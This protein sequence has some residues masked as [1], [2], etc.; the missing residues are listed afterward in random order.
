MPL[1]K[2]AERRH[3]HTRTVDCAGYRRSDG[4]WDIE[5]HLTDV[6]SYG[7]ANAERGTIEPGDP[8]HEMW[9]RVTV[10]DRLTIVAIE[11]QTDKSPFG[12][13]GAIT[14]A[15]QQLVGLSMVS[16]FTR[17]VK[18]RVGGVHGCTHLAE[19]LGPVATTAFQTVFPI[20]SRERSEKAGVRRG[21]T[22]PPLLN[23]CHAFASDGEL[24]RQLWPNHYTGPE[25]ALDV[26]S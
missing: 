16:G 26:A 11:A 1:S 19:L 20:L 14:P 5:G 21:D 8:I 6:K 4:L 12:I 24:V 10:D 17:K 15:F 3:I 23:T 9:I 25:K 2:P 18:E 7:F 13:C 22:R